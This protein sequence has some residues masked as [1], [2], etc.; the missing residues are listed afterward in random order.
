MNTSKT[1]F[2]EDTQTSSVFRIQSCV[3]VGLC[4]CMFWDR[5]GKIKLHAHLIYFVCQSRRYPGIK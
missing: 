4:D 5:C 3:A 1:C 2:C